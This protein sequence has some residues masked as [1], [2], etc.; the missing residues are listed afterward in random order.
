MKVNRNGIST[1]CYM[2]L[3]RG[4][5][6]QLTCKYARG[7]HSYKLLNKCFSFL[8]NVIYTR[9]RL[10]IIKNGAFL[11]LVEIFFSV[12]LLSA[13]KTVN[14]QDANLEIAWC[15][16]RWII[17]GF[18]SVRFAES[19]VLVH[20]NS[21]T[22]TSANRDHFMISSHE[23]FW[24]MAEVFVAVNSHPWILSA[25]W[26]QWEQECF[27][28]T[29]VSLPLTTIVFHIPFA[30]SRGQICSE[31]FIIARL[32]HEKCRFVLF[33]SDE[34]RRQGASMLFSGV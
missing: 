6:L 27:S 33:N 28:C 1:I 11:A 18:A 16:Q 4:N 12:L 21:L 17:K 10:F 9:W 2:T 32:Y 19:D 8:V 30:P 15:A 3:T 14:F 34:E 24:S 25:F 5:R 22:I 31:Y 20:P 29:E 13:H 7:E 26:I 23:E